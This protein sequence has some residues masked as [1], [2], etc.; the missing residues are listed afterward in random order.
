VSTPFAS[1]GVFQRWVIVYIAHRRSLCEGRQTFAVGHLAL[2]YLTGKTSAK[3]LNVNINVPLALALSILPDTDLLIP[4]LQHGG[5]T[6]SL[7]LYLAIAVPAILVWKKQTVPYL[8]A[9]ASH[10][11]LGDYL[12]RPSRA[13]GIQLF[14]PLTSSWFSAGS[15]AAVLAY[16][17]LELALFTAFLMLML[18]TRDIKILIKQHPSNLLLAIPVSTALLPVFLRFPIPVPPELIIPHIILIALLTLPILVDLK[19]ILTK[20]QR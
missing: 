5:P 14:F 6:H 10:P 15:E 19:T 13:Q 20:T 4:M 11:L 16:I 3:F 2:G 9:L 17:Y 18:A 12:T 7:I 8:I 1:F